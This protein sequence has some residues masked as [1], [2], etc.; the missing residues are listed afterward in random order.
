M[1]WRINLRKRW[2]KK[3]F[4]IPPPLLVC[5]ETNPGP[6][7]EDQRR[8]IVRWK[9]D[10][11]SNKAIAAKFGLKVK[12]VRRWV[13]RGAAKEPSFMNRRGQGRKRKLT[14]KQERAVY[15]KAKVKNQ[16]AP[17]IARELSKH[18]AGGVSTDTV[19]RTLKRRGLRYLVRKKQEIITPQQ[20]EKRLEFAQKRLEDDWKYALFTDEKTFQVG[21]H[22]HKSWQDP[23]DRAVDKV[24]RHQ[25][26]IHVWG[27]IGL[28]FKTKLFS[29][30]RT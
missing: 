13:R 3:K 5:V 4:M 25:A 30:N 7:S 12:V 17:E 8:D 23:N 28:H 26:K 21:G 1:V 6:I 14:A 19:Q 27:G 11:L 24:K 29:F 2:I 22:K 18:I 20:A 9:K 16:D 15:K 10:G